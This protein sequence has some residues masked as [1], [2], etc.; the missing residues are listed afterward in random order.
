MIRSLKRGFAVT[1]LVLQSVGFAHAA[2]PYQGEWVYWQGCA[3]GHTAHLRLQQEGASVTGTWNDGTRAES[4]EGKLRGTV[5]E[6]KLHAGLCHEGNGNQDPTRCPRYGPETE[7]TFV[8][9][10]AELVWYRDSKRYLTLHPFVKGM[11]VP[12]DGHNCADE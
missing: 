12:V 4:S 11:R 7:N 6:D 3:W 10:G 5:R 8:R 2:D 1:V 9:H